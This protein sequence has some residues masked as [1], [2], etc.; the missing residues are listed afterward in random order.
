MKQGAIMKKTILFSAMGMAMALGTTAQAQEVG[1]VVSS[2]PVVQQVAVPRQVC[3]TAV[4]QRP[5]SG[6]GAVLGAIVGGLLG[7]TIGHGT[8]RAA[9]TGVGLIGGAAVGDSLETR[10]QQ[11]VQQCTTQTTYENRTV[12]YNVV[13]EYAGKQFSVQ[14]PN[15]PG[16]TIRLQLTPVGGTGAEAAPAAAAP[17]SSGVVTAPPIGQQAVSGQP[18]GQIVGTS[19][20]TASYPVA[21]APAYYPAYPAYYPAYS[22]YYYPPIGLS[23]SFGYSGGYHHH[24]HWH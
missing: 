11:P 21:A 23:L 19:T 12:A 10:G 22:P 14:M 24:G 16:P 18:I 20:T 2:T 13:Y 9:A 5:S 1:R 7:N 4:V 3:N 8:G 6:G 17:G 15:D